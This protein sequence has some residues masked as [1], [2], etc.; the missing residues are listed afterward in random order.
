LSE[1]RKTEVRENI[2]AYCLAQLGKYYNL[3]FLNSKTED[4]FYC[5]QLAY[6]AYLKNGIDLNTDRG[7]PHVPGSHSIIFP[8]ELWS[9]CVNKKA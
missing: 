8:Q 9:G 2:A 3:N 7:V 4:S 6:L 5:S 1:S